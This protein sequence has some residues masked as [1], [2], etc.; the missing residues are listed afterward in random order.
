MNTAVRIPIGTPM[1]I[2]PAVTYRLPMIIGKIPYMSFFGLHNS[3]VRNFPNPI[4][5]IAGIPF[6]NKKIQMSATAS[7]EVQAATANTPCMNFSVHAF[8]FILF[9]YLI[10]CGCITSV[11]CLYLITTEFICC[12]VFIYNNCN[13]VCSNYLAVQFIFFFIL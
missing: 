11:N 6:A 13:T 3:P 4:L 8:D 9:H 1:I 12:I 7:T 10:P 5:L 2:A